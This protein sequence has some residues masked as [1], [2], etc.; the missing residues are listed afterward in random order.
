MTRTQI[1]M[2]NCGISS[3]IEAEFLDG[4]SIK[5]EIRSDCECVQRFAEELGEIDLSQ[6]MQPMKNSIVYKTS[7]KYLRHAACLLPGAIIRTIEVE[8]GMALPGTSS[9]ST[10]KS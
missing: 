6:L 8:V 4:N 3:I 2:D 5:L 1:C 7:A 10:E 9:V